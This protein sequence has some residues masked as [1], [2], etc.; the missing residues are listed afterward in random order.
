MSQRIRNFLNNWRLL[1]VILVI[2]GLIFI[3][4][5]AFYQNQ[6]KNV[7]SNIISN[8]EMVGKSIKMTNKIKKDM[9]KKVKRDITDSL[10]TPSTAV[11]PNMKDW[12]IY[13]DSNNVIEV[14]AYVDSQNSYGA[15]LR[16]EFEQHYIVTNKNQYI[17]IYKEFDD[18]IEFDITENTQYRKFVNKK[19]SDTQMQ[20]FI[21]KIKNIT[22][23]GEMI[24]YKFNRLD[25]S[26]EINLLVETQ[27]SKYRTYKDYVQL[28]ICEYVTQCICIPTVKTKLNIRN[29]KGELVA[30]V[31][32]VDL[33]FLIG[34]GHIKW[35]SEI[36]EYSNEEYAKENLKDRVWFSDEIN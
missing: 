12:K 16:A 5:I 36:M 13:V 35:D 31:D 6:T 2:V 14:K 3:S 4:A 17:C 21:E 15:M 29:E 23:W 10:K 30:K 9:Y 22:D 27:E 24:D 28:V 11:F 19:V 26:L 32:S 20:D 18:D 8:Y 33:K 34:E 25:Q 1:I 7:S